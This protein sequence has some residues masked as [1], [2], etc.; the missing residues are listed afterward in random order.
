M[1]KVTTYLNLTVVTYKE[2]LQSL[3]ALNLIKLFR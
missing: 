2:I 1:S 3:T